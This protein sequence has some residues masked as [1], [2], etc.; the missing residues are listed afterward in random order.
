[1]AKYATW[2][3]TNHAPETIPAWQ[4]AMVPREQIEIR[5]AGPQKLDNVLSSESA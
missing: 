5:G 1:M 4:L 3:N 2:F